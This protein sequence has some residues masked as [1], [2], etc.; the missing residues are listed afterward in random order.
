MKSR[1][2]II[3]WTA[4]LDCLRLLLEGLSY[5][6]EF[7]GVRLHIITQGGSVVRVGLEE[8]ILRRDIVE[9]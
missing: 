3:S 8:S 4:F 6:D 2:R 1:S 5:T 7:A 9:A